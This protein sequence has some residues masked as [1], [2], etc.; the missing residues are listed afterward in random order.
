MLFNSVDF[1]IFFPVIFLLYWFVFN[2]NVTWRNLFLLVAS[3]V[4]YGFWDWRFLPLIAASSIID[5]F[6]GRQ[7]GKTGDCR[8]RKIFL[9]ASLVINLGILGFFKYYNFFAESFVDVFSLFGKKF[10]H[11]T[12]DIILPIGVSFYTFQ[13]LSYIIDIYHRKIEPTGKII[14]FCTFVG[15]FPQL[16]AGPIERAKN[17]LPQFDTLKRFDYE[18]TRKG[19]LL[20]VGGLF[21]KI[22]IADRLAIFVDSAYGDIASASGA[23][24][25]CAIIFFAFQ[26]YFDFSAYSN[27]AVGT[28]QILGFSL[29]VNFR[30]PYLSGS[31]SEFWTRWHITLSSWFRDYVYIPIGGNRKGRARTTVNVMAVFVLSGLWHGASWNFIVWGAINALLMIIL[32]RLFGLEKSTGLKRIAGAVLVFTGWAL[33][34]VFF[35]VPTFSGAINVF[36][37]L[38]LNAAETIYQF[39]LNITEFKF[40]IYL[41][42]GMML[43]EILVERYGERLQERFFA[44]GRVFRW[45]VY[46]GLVLCIVYLGSYGTSS[47]NSFIYF[48]F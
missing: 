42:F 23:V 47:D 10:N 8:K 43:Y 15:F 16:V 34:L 20:I 27:I 21:K 41:L 11:A 28:A 46:L 7:I 40:A 12:L 29:S 17:L 19:M 6:L 37:N 38:G 24:L 44:A 31:F 30:R 36:S 48:Q 33:S 2:R 9:I 3:Y 32:D 5:F 14:N 22:V 4:F 45:A 39:G 1:A 13:S 26:L 25:S 35:R 18:A